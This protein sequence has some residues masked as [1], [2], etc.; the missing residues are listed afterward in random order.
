M[1]FSVINCLSWKTL[2]GKDIFADMVE[3]VCNQRPSYTTIRNWVAEFKRGRDVKGKH[4]SGRPRFVTT[5]EKL[6][7]WFDCLWLHIVYNDL[8]MRKDSEIPK[9]PY[10]HA[11]VHSA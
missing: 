1:S 9:G 5:R 7:I 8:N 11:L 3:T 6:K 4:C 2:S 10:T